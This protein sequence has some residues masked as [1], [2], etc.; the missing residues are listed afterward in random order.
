MGANF[1]LP[2]V[3]RVA[4]FS[5]WRFSKKSIDAVV[6]TAQRSPETWPAHGGSDGVERRLDEAPARS[7]C[8]VRTCS[9]NPICDEEGHVRDKEK[10]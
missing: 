6:R 4:C 10:R 9:G 8:A 2:V 5:P 3:G 7:A 1:R